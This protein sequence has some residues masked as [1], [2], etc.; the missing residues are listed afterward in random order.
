MANH[1]LSQSTVSHV[2]F[3]LNFPLFKFDLILKNR[4]IYIHFQISIF[5]WKV[6]EGLVTWGCLPTGQQ[7]V[8]ANTLEYSRFGHH[9]CLLSHSWQ[10][11]WGGSCCALEW[12]GKL[13]FGQSPPIS[14]T[15]SCGIQ[16]WWDFRWFT[17]LI[18]RFPF[19]VFK[20]VMKVVFRATWEI[21]LLLSAW[22]SINANFINIW[23]S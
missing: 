2:L 8:G 13:T 16:P 12:S 3:G 14:S 11:I 1:A 6:R 10:G 7:F 5:S 22:S 9:T 15:H 23:I 18:Y 4:E 21:T 20:D 17:S 19:P